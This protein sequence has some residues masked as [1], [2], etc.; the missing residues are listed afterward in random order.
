M[1]SAEFVVFSNGYKNG[2][3]HPH[4][5]IESRARSL[6]MVSLAAS[7]IGMQ[8]YWFVENEQEMFPLLSR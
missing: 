2:F 3:N 1:V 4:P 7:E 5:Q 6:G 8:S